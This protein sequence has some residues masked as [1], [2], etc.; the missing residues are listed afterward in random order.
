MRTKEP[1]ERLQEARVSAGYS[2]VADAV[3]AFGWTYSTYASHENGTRKLSPEAARRYAGALRVSPAWLLYGAEK[4]RSIEPVSVPVVGKVAAGLWLDAD[5]YEYAD[6]TWVPAVKSPEFRNGNQV[7]YKVEG[8]S[9][10]RILPDGSYA[11][12]VLFES[13]RQPRH[14]DVVILRRT[15]AGLVETTVKRYLVDGD[16]VLLMPE[17]DDP[18]Y[19]TPIDLA[20][21]EE[22]T[23]VEVHALVVGSYRPL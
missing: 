21:V 9:M 16:K 5:S 17:S 19:Q 3:T 7:A 2:S 22:D 10:N 14:R 4:D 23:Q 15:R 13:A 20:A 18:R 12:G 6:E 11:I 1:F 8:P